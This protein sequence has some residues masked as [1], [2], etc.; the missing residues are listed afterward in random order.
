MPFNVVSVATINGKTTGQ[1]V[2][3]SATAI[4]TNPSASGKT[5]KINALMCSNKDTAASYSVTVYLYK[6]ATPYVVVPATPIAPYAALDVLNKSVY[7]EEGDSIQ[8]LASAAAKIDAI[9]SYEDM[10]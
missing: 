6:G 7:L 5:L 4:V 10:S 1:A 9:C 8:L 3:T 2:G